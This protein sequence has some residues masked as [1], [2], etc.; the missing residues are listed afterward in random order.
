MIAFL[1]NLFFRDV[2]LKLFS[3]GLAILI[4]FIVWLA[5]Q[6]E[7]TPVAASTTKT[8]E[9]TFFGV[10]VVVVSG[11]ADVRE[12]KVRPSQIEIRVQGE[13]TLVESLRGSDIRAMVDLTGAEVTAELNRRVEV[14]T[15]AGIMYVRVSPEEV[16]VLA[17]A[18]PKS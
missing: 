10:P 3:F 8:S 9:R 2:W 6:K 7:A 4:W 14:F 5:I 11:T 13:T 16:Q 15:P 1:R 12:F 18:P 17:P